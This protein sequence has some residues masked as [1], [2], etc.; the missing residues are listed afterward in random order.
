[1][2]CYISREIYLMLTDK[3]IARAKRTGKINRNTV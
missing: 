1:M 3:L 2:C